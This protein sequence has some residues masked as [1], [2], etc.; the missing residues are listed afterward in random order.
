MKKSFIVLLFFLSITESSASIKNKIIQNL[1]TTKNLTFNFRI[2]FNPVA[3]LH[4]RFVITSSQANA[5]TF[6]ILIF[7]TAP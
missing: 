4:Q 1:E 2:S 6:R 3:A 5:A 7:L